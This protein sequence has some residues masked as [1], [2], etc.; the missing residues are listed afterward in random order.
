MNCCN[1][2]SIVVFGLSASKELANKVAIELGSPLSEIKIEKFADGEIIVTPLVPV[3]GKKVVIIQS[4]AK[5]VNDNLMELLIAIDAIKRASAKSI[6]VVIP[7]YGYARQDR[8]AKPREPISSR[9]VAK[10]L[11]AAGANAVL[12]WDI[13]SLQ[14]Q[15]FFD[16]SF[17]SLEGAWMLMDNYID[18]NHYPNDL[19]IV[20]PDYG[21]VKRAREISLVL[22][23]NL[24]IV[25]KRRSG[26]NEV[27]I[28]NILGD[29]EGQNCI[30]VDDMI[31]TGGTILGAAKIVKEKGAKTVSILATHGLF[32]KNAI[33][34][35]SNAINS[36]VIDKVY[37]TDTIERKE[38]YPWLHIVS[39]APVIAECIKI[40][41][42]E[43]G[44]MS[45]VY[46]KYSKT[47]LM[48][49]LKS[50]DIKNK[51]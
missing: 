42:K 4:T 5:P 41:E 35:F 28:N 2:K 32:N 21:C 51:N 11:E 50:C 23:S 43:I 25:D 47:T 7:Y 44:T 29:V 37:V 17:D 10:M 36:G 8:K 16:I 22:K 31:D 1:E 26:K 6:A 13:H 48:N 38:T 49:K 40:Y 30:L 3:R 33:E 24:A 27:E 12:T 15:G 39:I 19:T 18:L 14:T 20:S 46:E 9:L 34:N 45:Q